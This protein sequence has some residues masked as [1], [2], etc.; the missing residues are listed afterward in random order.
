MS[1]SFSE[2]LSVMSSVDDVTICCIGNGS[3]VV[4]SF[5]LC[6]LELQPWHPP[7]RVMAPELTCVIPVSTHCFQTEFWCWIGT[8]AGVQ[9]K[10]EQTSK[11][12]LFGA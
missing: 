12:L 2:A 8:P 11:P 6:S 7:D 5:F 10:R 1:A 4:V 9:K 3:L